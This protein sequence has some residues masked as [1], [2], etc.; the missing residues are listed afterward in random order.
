MLNE[1]RLISCLIIQNLSSDGIIIADGSSGCSF[2]GGM[3]RCVQE[4]LKQIFGYLNL[5][6]RVT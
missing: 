1:V 2:E 3:K 5:N 4:K 6:S